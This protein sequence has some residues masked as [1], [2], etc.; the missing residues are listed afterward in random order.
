MAKVPPA[1]IAGQQEIIEGRVCLL[2]LG[3]PDDPFGIVILREAWEDGT[4][5]VSLID[6]DRVLSQYRHKRVRVTIEL[7]A[8]PGEA[9]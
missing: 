8:E 5:D 6:M 4:A 1:M 9:K 2:R 7:V 3:L